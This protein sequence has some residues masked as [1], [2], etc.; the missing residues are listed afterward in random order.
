MFGFFVCFHLKTRRRH[1]DYQQP[2]LSYQNTRT[3][4]VL[5]F[6]FLFTTTYS[7]IRKPY[8][9]DFARKKKPVYSPSTY[10]ELNQ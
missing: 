2:R 8:L 9:Q 7:K 10:L 1:G 5:N 6:F 3:V 4:F